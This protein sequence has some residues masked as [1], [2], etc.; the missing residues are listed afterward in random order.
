MVAPVGLIKSNWRATLP[1]LAVRVDCRCPLDFTARSVQI[2]ALADSAPTRAVGLRE[3][4]QSKAALWSWEDKQDTRCMRNVASSENGS[5]R[6]IP[7][8]KLE[9]EQK[10]W[11]GA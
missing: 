7:M 10:A 1:P 3:G 9:Q 4:H 11:H 5:V 6:R 8:L 2:S